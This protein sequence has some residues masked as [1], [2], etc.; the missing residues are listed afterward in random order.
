MIH[1][2]D[3][4]TTHSTAKMLDNVKGESDHFSTWKKLFSQVIV[5]TKHIHR[6]DF[7]PTTD[8]SIVAKKVISDDSLCSIFKNSDDMKLVK[9]LC[10]ETHLSLGEGAFVPEHNFWKPGEV[11]I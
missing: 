9:I 4:H 6:N 5:R 3:T 8:S 1:D 2:L 11:M 10:N 7:Y